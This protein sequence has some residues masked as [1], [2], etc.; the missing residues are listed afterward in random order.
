[1]ISLV[2]GNR[3]CLAQ[4]LINNS[5]K[6]A[7]SV[8]KQSTIAACMAHLAFHSLMQTRREQKQF[9]ACSRVGLFTVTSSL[10]DP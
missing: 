7:L 3:L 6:E 5:W 8:N 2:N 10:D 4:M 1:M 9:D